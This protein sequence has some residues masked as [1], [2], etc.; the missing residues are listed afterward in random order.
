VGIGNASGAST[1]GRQTQLVLGKFLPQLLQ[2][3][4]VYERSSLEIGRAQPE[5]QENI[6]HIPG[7]GLRLQSVISRPELLAQTVDGNDSVIDATEMALAPGLTQMWGQRD[8]GLTGAGYTAPSQSMK[9]I[10]RSVAT[11]WANSLT[12]DQ[13]AFPGPT[14]T[15]AS[16]MSRMVRTSE[17][18]DPRDG[19]SFQ[20]FVPGRQV[21][22][23]DGICRLYFTGP[24]G[25]TAGARGLGQ[26]CIDFRGDGVAL[27]YERFNATET[28][29][30]EWR[31]VFAF[32]YTVGNKGVQGSMFSISVVS[33]SFE[34]CGDL[35]EGDRIVFQTSQSPAP[36]RAGL[37]AFAS[38]LAIGVLSKQSS[39]YEVP[40]YVDRLTNPSP[41]PIRLDAL[42][43]TRFTLQLAKDRFPD[44]GKIVDDSFDLPFYPT[45]SQPIFLEW[46]GRRPDGTAVTAKLIRDDTGAELSREDVTIDD[47]LGE[48]IRYTCP[49]G[50]R[51]FHVEFDLDP[52]TGKRF[53]PSISGYKV[54]RFPLI[55]TL[56]STPVVH[57]QL[58]EGQP[59]KTV[60]PRVDVVGTGENPMVENAQ[61]S[62]KDP[63]G[64]HEYLQ[65]WNGKPAAIEVADEASGD[66]VTLIQGIC[67]KST[68]THIGTDKGSGKPYGGKDYYEYDLTILSEGRRLMRKRCPS[69]FQFVEKGTGKPY[70]VTDAIRILLNAAG[71]PDS[72]L[73]IP[74]LPIRLWAEGT[75]ENSSLLVNVETP[76]YDLVMEWVVDILGA[77][78]IWDA[79]AGSQ[80]M[81]R[82]LQRKSPPYQH[83]LRFD[84]RQQ[85]DG[86]TFHALGSYGGRTEGSGQEIQ[87]LPVWREPRMRCDYEAPEANLV[88]VYGYSSEGS[89]SP[90]TGQ[91]YSRVLFNPRSY[92]AGGLSPS[93]SN[94]PD[95][96]GPE[97]IGEE[98]S[99]VKHDR[100]L[101]SQSA[102]DWVARRIFDY[103]CIGRQSWT[104]VSALPFVM[105]VLDPLQE[106]LRIPRFYDP[107]EFVDQKGVVHQCVIAACN[108]G[109]GVGQDRYQ[110]A[111]YTVVTSTSMDRYASPLGPR[112]IHR[113]GQKRQVRNAVWQGLPPRMPMIN[114]SNVKI[115]RSMDVLEGYPTVP[116]NPIQIID[117]MNA[118]FGDFLYMPDYDPLS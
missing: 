98:V 77:F 102:V 39:T 6:Q 92:N 74:E 76:I 8:P 56:T 84:M 49:A 43:S 37:I 68:A 44:S 81:W 27:L 35:Y 99:I 51:S 100:T 21:G 59:P 1:P 94:Y 106:R 64:L 24:A 93:D 53:S 50:V 58:V 14:G 75:G 91:R 20:F 41:A 67:D 118:N 96:Y 97:M 38:S 60:I 13:T 30:P 87:Y 62:V 73:D 82:I 22:R 18:H 7:I 40:R 55:E 2:P 26:Y 57:P 28:W 115:G 101:Q 85:I 52:D 12:V 10:H 25:H 16:N 108:P 71:Y 70:K 72:M 95:I 32:P 105:D 111:V 83:L 3:L 54:V 116:S 19:I 117:P 29:D 9:V 112:S 104:F 80:G 45:G 4:F 61:I 42:A 90:N 103:T 48:Q 79:S 15:Y 107:V 78:L 34:T 88:A 31:K 110:R 11:T 89:V 65:F 66:Q 17:N 86:H 63:L 47:C 46:Y 36:D 113:I 109:W 114:S 5:K 33:N 69:R 23:S